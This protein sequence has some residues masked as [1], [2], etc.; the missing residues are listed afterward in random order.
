VL[1]SPVAAGSAESLLSQIDKTRLPRHIAVIMDGNGRWAKKRGLPR[2][3]GHKAGTESVREAVKVC[4]ELGV[5]ALTLYAFSTENWS[6]PMDEVKGLMT[7]L[8]HTLRR[9]VQDLDKSN[10]RLRTSGRVDKLPKDVQKELQK[11]I[12]AL[13]GNTGLILNLALNYGGRQDIV[14]AANALLRAGKKE[15]TEEDLSAHLSTAG[16]PDPDLL[17]RTSGEMRISNFLLW[18]CAYAEFHITPILWPD[19]RR[20]QIYEAVLDYQSRHRRFGGL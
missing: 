17:I 7:L 11:S 16:L 12:D 10:V 2:L 19:F 6:R 18:Q 14:D 13:A 8:I 15:V 20:P 3:L 9:E 5:E 4:G 1:R